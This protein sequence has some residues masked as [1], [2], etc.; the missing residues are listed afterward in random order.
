MPALRLLLL[1]LIV[2]LV[3]LPAASLPV[4]QTPEPVCVTLVTRAVETVGIACDGITRNQACYG[5]QLIDV[6]FLP[7]QSPPFVVSGDVV[8]L[9]SLRR[10]STMPYDSA[11]D[12]WGIAVIK[13]QANLPDA[14][15]GQN[16]T[17]LL[18]GDAALDN[19]TP[20]MQIVTVETSITQGVTCEQAPSGVLIQSPR[21]SQ[22]E[23]TL[24]GASL[25][26]G[27]T[28]YVRAITEDQLTLVTLDGAA[29]LSAF[30]QVRVVLEGYQVT[31]QI[32]A[33]HQVIG[34]PSPAVPF[35]PSLLQYLPI[36]LLDDEIFL[37]EPLDVPATLTPAASPTACARRADWTVRY[38]VQSGDTLSTIA[39]RLGMNTFSLQS[40]NCIGN[41][42]LIRAG[43]SLNVPFAVPTLVPPITIT[44][45]VT[46]PPPVSFYADS[47][48]INAGECTT[49]YWFVPGDDV[50]SVYIDQENVEPQGSSRYCSVETQTITLTVYRLDQ[51]IETY[52][53]TI[54]VLDVC[55]DSLCTGTEDFST[56]PSDCG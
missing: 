17:F 19:P 56:C 40:A 6:E 55:G 26:L 36:S 13:A 53:I 43:D 4:A 27:S 33:D 44:P 32:D 30:D 20:D 35:D 16:V 54:T 31:V 45:S 29:V 12:Q 38:I 34:E 46:M 48:T 37:P 47:Y 11:L 18:F 7:D 9:G 25:I 52:P 1:V 14:I 39:G 8:D 42:N 24:N 15:P 10:I 5:N 49:L 51:S 28:V 41:P 23:M 22:V 21:G 3:S 2:S 50:A